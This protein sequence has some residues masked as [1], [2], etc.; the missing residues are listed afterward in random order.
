MD[1]LYARDQLLVYAYGGLLMKPLMLHNIVE[2]LT[3][4]TELHDEVEFCVCLNNL[5][6]LDYI[7]MSHF[8]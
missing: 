7:G 8:L 6:K 2:E 3:V 4:R 1:V 5:I